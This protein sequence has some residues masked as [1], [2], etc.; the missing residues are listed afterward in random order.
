MQ[1]RNRR[2]GRREVLINAGQAVAYGSTMAVAFVID[3]G[4]FKDSSP[5]P[6][7]TLINPDIP[8]PPKAPKIEGGRI[9][10]A[11][12]ISENELISFYNSVIDTDKNVEANPKIMRSTLYHALRFYGMSDK[13]AR[14]RTKT[15]SIDTEAEKFCRG[16]IA[17]SIDTEEGA[18]IA[19]NNSFF[20]YGWSGA[21]QIL[22]HEAAHS[23]IDK[24]DYVKAVESYGELGSIGVHGDRSGFS[25]DGNYAGP[26][27]YIMYLGDPIGGRINVAEEYFAEVARR[28]YV[29]YLEG[30]GLKKPELITPYEDLNF[31]INQL[32]DDHPESDVAWRNVLGKDLS[33]ESMNS[34]HKKNDRR[35]FFMKIGLD[36]IG[37]NKNGLRLSSENIAAVGLVFFHDFVQYDMSKHEISKSLLQDPITDLRVY[38]YSNRILLER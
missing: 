10:D 26:V 15:I 7:S 23:A 19:V 1:E 35:G 22:A 20:E 37:A 29:K 12:I 5:E 4:L 21:L 8:I 3:R 31:A 32:V 13:I 25:A 28:K 16:A 33:F 11:E 36:L 18:I 27:D 17:C 2:R 24:V 14:E 6:S 30:R 38:D 34:Y 9:T